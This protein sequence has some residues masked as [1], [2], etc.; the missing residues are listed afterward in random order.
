M[1]VV[2]TSHPGEWF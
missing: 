2:N 1:D